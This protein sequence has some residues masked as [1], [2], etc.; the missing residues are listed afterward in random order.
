MCFPQGIEG[1][2]HRFSYN[3]RIVRATVATAGF[4]LFASLTDVQGSRTP[5]LNTS[6]TLVRE[7][8]TFIARLQELP[9]LSACLLEQS[10]S[11]K[12]L[13]IQSTSPKPSHQCKCTSIGLQQRFLHGARLSLT[14]EQRNTFNPASHSLTCVYPLAE[15]NYKL[16][17][18]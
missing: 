8:S 16:F 18:H 7:Q 14:Q 9:A 3:P 12:H 6:C 15:L 1:A 4:H 10:A 2:A 5:Q 13:D 17:A 11:E